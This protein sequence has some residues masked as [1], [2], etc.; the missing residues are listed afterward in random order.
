M[1]RG[2]GRGREGTGKGGGDYGGRG[3]ETPPIHAPNPYFWI[4][5]WQRQLNTEESF[6]GINAIIDIMKIA[7]QKFG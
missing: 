4:H 1:G 3:D 6:K 7:S 5:P 2:G